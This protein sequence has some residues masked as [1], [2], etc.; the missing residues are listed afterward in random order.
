[1]TAE[2]AI[3]RILRSAPP[4]DAVYHPLGHAFRQRRPAFR[5]RRGRTA[6]MARLVVIL[7]ILGFSGAALLQIGGPQSSTYPM[8]KGGPGRTGEAVGGGPA[9][10]T[11]LWSVDTEPVIDSSP[12]VVEGL[13]YLVDGDGHLRALDLGTGATRWL[14]SGEQ[15]VGSPAV[16]G[17]LVISLA[18]DGSLLAHDRRDGTPRWRTQARLRANSSPLILDGRVFAAGDD[19]AVHAF[20]AVDGTP[21]WSVAM[22]SGL[23]RSIA[24]ADGRIF[25]GSAGSFVA[26]DAATGARLWAHESEAASFSTPA[27]RDGIVYANAGVGSSSVLFALDAGTGAERWRF[28]PPDGLGTITPSVDAS[29]VYVA[30]PERVYRLD[31]TDGSIAWAVEVARVSRAAIALAG[32]TIYLFSNADLHALDARSGTER[33]QLRVGGLVD[34]GT[35]VVDGLVVAGTSAGRIIAVGAPD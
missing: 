29:A 35:T 23:D 7:A 32:D 22:G 11:I 13:V 9:A 6:T 1:M 27:V 12:V 34:S 25:V 16:S 33:W 21:S 5:S 24:G 31:L 28:E 14:T 20:D 10:S 30:S 2:D 26:M 4:N 18:E 15:Q 17:A 8:Y 19:A 3:I